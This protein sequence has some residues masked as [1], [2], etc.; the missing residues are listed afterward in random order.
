VTAPAPTRPAVRKMGNGQL[1]IGE[2][3]SPLD[4]SGRC[5]KASVTW[6]VDSTDDTEV[7][8]GDVMAGDTEY[9]ATLEVTIYQD[10]LR[11]GGLVDSSWDLKG[12]EA[13]FLFVPF[14]GGRGIAGVLR[15]D[16]IDVG[17]DVG[18]KN[19]SELKWMCIGEPQLVDDIP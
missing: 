3:A 6:K 9:S 10:D 2:V 13:P 19:T 18:K 15:I 1:I 16:P 4:F 11:A 7:L 8:N 17:G 14:E 5:T 12:T